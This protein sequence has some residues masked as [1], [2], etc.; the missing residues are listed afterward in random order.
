MAAARAGPQRV[1]L[2]AAGVTSGAR[3]IR[4]AARNN[5]KAVTSSSWPRG[6]PGAAV[7]ARAAPIALGVYA[8]AAFAFAFFD[9]GRSI[10]RAA[11]AAL[12][13][14]TIN[15]VAATLAFR[16]A[17]SPRLPDPIRRT[18]RFFGLSTIAIL[19]GHV[20]WTWQA[21]VLGRTNVSPWYEVPFLVRYPFVLAG[22]LSLPLALRSGE[23][24]LRFILDAASVVVTGA[25]GIWYFILYPGR[26]PTGLAAAVALLYSVGDLVLLLGIATIWLRRGSFRG[27]SA[28]TL[29]GAGLLVNFVTNVAYALQVGAGTFRT[30][31][32][33]HPFW[34]AATCLVAAS[35]ERQYREGES[36]EPVTIA[37]P[38]RAAQPSLTPYVA[39]VAGYGLLL[40]VA[41]RIGIQPL[42]GLVLGAMVLTAL[43]VA[44]QVT[45][46]QENLRLLAEKSAEDSEA[47]FRALVQHSSDVIRILDP[48][49]T[50]R[51]ASPAVPASWAIRPRPWPAP[52]SST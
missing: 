28:F 37:A 46:V 23:D 43:V 31:G 52:A 49:T 19:V 24:R 10:V 44:R 27:G 32:V 18:W 2:E 25:M 51:F 1:W 35:A 8:A 14:L 41:A 3:W 15:A 48:D 47:R 36:P 33:L 21:V 16:N 29:L 26:T 4:E 20:L 34:V 11:F 17:R 12:A 38:G 30:G 40:V 13:L 6:W 9:V 22:I 50:I 42:A 7:L 45:A 39:L 5:L